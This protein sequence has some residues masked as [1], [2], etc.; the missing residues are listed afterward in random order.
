MSAVLEQPRP[1]VFTPAQ[2][3]DKR[4]VTAVDPRWVWF[5]GDL[6]VPER[7]AEISWLKIGGEETVSPCLQ[8]YGRGFVP[9]GYAAILETGGDPLPRRLLGDLGTAAWYG[10]T[11]AGRSTKDDMGLIPVFPGDGLRVLQRYARNPIRK[12]LDE[13][14]VLASRSWD[15]C[16]NDEGTGILDVIERAQFSDGQEPTLKGLEDQIRHAVVTDTRIDYG[17][18]RDQQLKMCED[19]RHWAGRAIAVEHGL[20]KI[21]HI[22]VTAV[23]NL[24]EGSIGGWSYMYSP[25]VEMLIAQLGI[26]RQDEPMHEMAKL[27]AQMAPQPSTGMSAA[28][29]DL[30][31]QRMEARLAKAREA[32]AKRI[33]ELEA[34]LN[35]VSRETFTCDGCGQE[36][37]S[38]AGK[39]AHERHCKVLNPSES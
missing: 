31:E 38:K 12:G 33:A 36:A 5:P 32:D 20:L 15:E 11:Q 13:L 39:L 8:R 6:I 22:P 10:I 37:A 25:V 18:M 26:T 30:I 14:E 9:R 23:P 21:G 24:P 35:E 3:Y 16:H 4:T 17:E 7:K 29:L 2:Y 28:D 19:F 27:V 1:E 34:K